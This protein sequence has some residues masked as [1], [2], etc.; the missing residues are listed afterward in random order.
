MQEKTCLF[1]LETVK[2]TEQMQNIIGCD[3]EIVC[4]GTCL[5]SWFE[6]KHQLECP[7]CHTVSVPNMTFQGQGDHVIAVVHVHR[8]IDQE[9]EL[10][11]I[12]RSHEKCMLWCCFGLLIW[13]I[14]VNVLSYFW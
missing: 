3:C 8:G 6:T 1:C 10:L 14:V 4:H 12:R 2:Q 11:R 13:G 5:Q 7:I 9:R